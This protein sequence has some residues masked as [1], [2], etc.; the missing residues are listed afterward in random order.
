[1]V[2]GLQVFLFGLFLAHG[3]NGRICCVEHGNHEF[4]WHPKCRSTESIMS[5]LQ[6][7]QLGAAK[8]GMPC[9]MCPHLGC[10]HS[11]LRTSVTPCPECDQGSLVLDPLRSLHPLPLTPTLLLPPNFSSSEVC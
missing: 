1:M 11:Y 8:G 2:L 9:T 3:D 6:Y 4:D 5:G 10:Q 7:G